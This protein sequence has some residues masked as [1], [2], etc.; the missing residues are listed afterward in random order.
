MCSG[1]PSW[2]QGPID[3]F[4]RVVPWGHSSAPAAEAAPAV[5][6]D[7]HD[8]KALPTDAHHEC[9]PEAAAPVPS[10]PPLETAKNLEHGL[11]LLK[12]EQCKRLEEKAHGLHGK[13]RALHD[14]I[15][16]IDTLL[17]LLSKYS[18]RNVDGTENKAGT[19]DCS[20][21]EIAAVVASLRR[22]GVSVPLPDGI[23]LK[24]ER[25]TIV[26]VL[27]NQRSLLSDEQKEHS[28]EFQQCAVER[29]SLYQALMSLIAEL[30]RVKVK[31]LQNL[32][33][34]SST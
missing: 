28:Q 15:K 12:A 13:V 9:S 2:L 20:I 18:Q 29:N 5:P 19:I 3:W 16:N 24:S 27:T 22:E 10:A 4:Q 6:S 33:R 32:H 25:G 34:S 30:H 7:Q 23:L 11:L 26:N 8:E 21:P 31:I 17:S 1:L 14:K